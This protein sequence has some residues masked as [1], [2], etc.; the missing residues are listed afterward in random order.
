MLEIPELTTGHLIR[1]CR[2]VNADVVIFTK[3]ILVVPCGNENPQ[4]NFY[5]LEKNAISA[6]HGF[7]LT[8]F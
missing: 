5:E 8:R 4:T 3:F 6:Y 7:N 1:L 2:D